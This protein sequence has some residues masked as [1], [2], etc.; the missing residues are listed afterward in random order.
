MDIL[1]RFLPWP[2]A[3]P[4]VTCSFMW[5]SMFS[6]LGMIIQPRSLRWASK[7]VLRRVLVD[8]ERVVGSSAKFPLG[9]V[10]MGKSNSTW[11][12]SQAWELLSP[13]GL[14]FR[15]LLA[16]VRSRTPPR[17]SSGGST[18]QG[19][20]IRSCEAATGFWMARRNSSMDFRAGDQHWARLIYWYRPSD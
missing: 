11:D 2:W 16:P 12:Y 18:S 6:K 13:N 19:L 15:M 7:I 17:H 8:A 4:F 10:H 3:W 20:Q 1:N 5:A 9:C 14:I